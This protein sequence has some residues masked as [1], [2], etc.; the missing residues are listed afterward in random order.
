MPAKNGP[1]TELANEPPH[2]QE[3]LRPPAPGTLMVDI[4]HDERVGE[5][6]GEWCGQWSLRPVGG[7][8]EWTVD[9]RDVRLAGPI[10]RLR[11]ELDR[12][13]RRSRGELL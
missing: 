11:A 10:E 9:P 1:P 6:R 13:N 12:A 7:G 3:P 8:V 2:G 4:S 5:F